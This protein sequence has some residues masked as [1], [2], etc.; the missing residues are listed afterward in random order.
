MLH[1]AQ[2]QLLEVVSSYLTRLESDLCP[3]LKCIT[4]YCLYHFLRVDPSLLRYHL[5]QMRKLGAKKRV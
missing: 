5:L 1:G 3:A 2:H 4:L